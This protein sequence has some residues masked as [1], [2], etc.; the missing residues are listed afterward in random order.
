LI[1]PSTFSI[2]A[3][4]PSQQTWGIAV[5]SKFPAAGAVVPWAKAGQGA[6]ATQAFANTSFGPQGLE[7]L[8]KG[9]DAETT[10]AQ[11]LASDPGRET[12]QVGIVDAQ[13][14]SA[15]FTGSE[16]ADWAGGLCAPSYAIQGN[17]LAGKHVIQAMET[18][19]LGTQA[20][21]ASRLHAALLAGDRA[22]GDR[23]GRQSAAMIV[24][25]ENGGYAG[26]NDR[27]FDY[28]VDDDPDPVAKLGDLLYLH[29]LYFEKSPETGRIQLQGE[30]LITVQKIMQQLGYLQQAPNGSHD[31]TSQE[32]LRAFMGNEN[33]EERSDPAV[34]WMDSPVYD[35]IIR[36][37]GK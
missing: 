36:K 21:L 10:L 34:G 17:I 30:K 16:C 4:D 19:F 24:V 6:I 1:H 26:F 2:A 8:S 13:G 32:A 12:R 31:T 3:Y 14:R 11:L 23:R 20:D 18:A 15:T 5:A 9:L 25:K 28:R 33:F 29:R 27:M 35:F 22:G 37:F 7:L